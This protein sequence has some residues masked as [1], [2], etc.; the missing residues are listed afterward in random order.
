MDYILISLKFETK[1]ND[2][3]VYKL[4]PDNTKPNTH[5]TNKK[6]SSTVLM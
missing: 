2:K 4:F 6:S 1:S 3:N 5:Q